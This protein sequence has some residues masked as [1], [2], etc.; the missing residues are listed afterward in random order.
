[1]AALLAVRDSCHTRRG[2]SIH[3]FPVKIGG[4]APPRVRRLLGAR[5]RIYRSRRV[6]ARSERWTFRTR[7]RQLPTGRRWPP[8]SARLFLGA[9]R[10]PTKKPTGRCV[11]R[12][13]PRRY[14]WFAADLRPFTIPIDVAVAVAAVIVAA[15]AWRQPADR[16]S[17]AADTR[18]L[19]WA[20]AA[21]WL[22][23]FGLLAV[24]E[25]AAYL[26]S[27]RRD[28]PTLSSMADAL[29]NTHPGRAAAFA[30]WLLLG[31]ALL[32]RRASP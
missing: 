18:P 16:S 19:R 17:K 27:P 28:H 8:G 31:W 26:S 23:T 9:L 32:L 6:E 15:L 11:G 24:F 1:M 14:C 29:M 22:V 4:D 21:P 12:S 2:P 25:V 3:S 10:G 20:D 7:D 5:S 13:H 30:L